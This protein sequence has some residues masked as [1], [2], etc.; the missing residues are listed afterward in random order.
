[1]IQ[2]CNISFS[3]V[4]TILL[5]TISCL[6]ET[7]KK[8]CLVGTSGSGKTTLLRCITQ[9]EQA[10]TGTIL[11]QGQNIK[12]SAPEK[13]ASMVGLVSQHFNLF[14]HLSL[15]NNCMQPLVV[16]QKLSKKEA[17]ARVYDL[18]EALA[19]QE[20]ADA[21]PRELSGG[22]QQRAALVRT[23]ALRPP[24]VCLDEPTSALDAATSKLVINLLQGPLYAQTTCLL[25]SHDIPFVEAV[26][27]EVY[28]L[29]Q[30][31]LAKTVIT[32]Q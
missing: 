19:I 26:A 15:L 27:D 5:N 17:L 9:L 18:L 1:M 16:T 3:Y 10:Y 22:Q 4:N 8:V 12:G 25:A 2:L 21:Y 30:G 20:V 23:L 32:K 31:A 29:Q 11:L 7:G 28:Q 24:V 6:I 14:P 13:R